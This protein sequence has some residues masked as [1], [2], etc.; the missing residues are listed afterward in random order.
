MAVISLSAEMITPFR[1][2]PR[3]KVNGAIPHVAHRLRRTHRD[4]VGFLPYKHTG[5]SCNETTA[6]EKAIGVSKRSGSQH[7][8]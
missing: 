4:S 5:D 8:N 2:E 3:I 1:L 7:F 6:G